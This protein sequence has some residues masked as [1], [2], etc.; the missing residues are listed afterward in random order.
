MNTAARAAVR[1]GIAKGWTMLSE[2]TAHGPVWQITA[3]ELTWE[4]VGRLG[5]AMVLD[6]PSPDSPHHEYY[7][8]GQKWIE[9]MR[10]M[11]SGRRRPEAT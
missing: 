11:R 5:F 6:T 4:D 7:A 9:L 8:L 10:S 3:R 2:L 1:L